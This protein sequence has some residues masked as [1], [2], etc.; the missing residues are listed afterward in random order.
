MNKMILFF[1]TMTITAASANAQNFSIGGNVGAGTTSGYKLAAGG[2]VQV[3]IPATTGLKITASAGYQNWAFEN[4]GFKG[5]TSF[6]PILAGAKFNLSS[7][8]YGHGQLGYSV[9]TKSGG[10]G[11][12]TYAPSI[13][14]MISN[15][16][17]LSAKYMGLSNNGATVSALFARLAYTFG[18]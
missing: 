6:I 12:F 17:D 3:D 15:N 5:H 8:L 11:S 2:D 14:Y 1:A 18:K 16:L 7:K 4:N 9:S 10:G 13:G